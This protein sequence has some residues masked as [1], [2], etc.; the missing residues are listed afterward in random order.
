MA[1]EPKLYPPGGWVTL[2]EEL[3]NY[4]GASDPT[5]PRH[6]RDVERM[7]VSYAQTMGHTRHNPLP[8]D[9]AICAMCGDFRE[10]ARRVPLLIVSVLVKEN[11]HIRRVCS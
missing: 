1:N 11:K 7:V 6:Y 8:E 9:C 5:L 2:S 3:A 4:L 10:R